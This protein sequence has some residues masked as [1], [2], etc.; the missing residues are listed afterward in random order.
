MRDVMEG[1]P[2]RSHLAHLRARVRTKSTKMLVSRQDGRDSCGA[3]HLAAKPM[4]ALRCAISKKVPAMSGIG[5]IVWIPNREADSWTR[6]QV[7][8][9]YACDP[10]GRPQTSSPCARRS[11]G[12][13]E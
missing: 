9:A 4:R 2:G 8:P 6:I 1:D 13:R 11:V 5:E 3:I 10:G 7:G 12:R